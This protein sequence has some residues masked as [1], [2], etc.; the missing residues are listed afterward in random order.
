MSVN[1]EHQRFVKQVMEAAD[2]VDVISEVV[3]LKARS[4]ARSNSYMG[5]C[6]FHADRSPSFS[7]SGEKQL[8]HCFGCDAGLNGKQGGDVITFVRRQYDMKFREAV[9][10]L[11]KRYGIQAPPT[12]L[13]DERGAQ[14]TGV[15]DVPAGTLGLKARPTAFQFETKEDDGL[16]PEQRKERLLEPMRKAHALYASLYDSSHEAKNYLENVR[17]ISAQTLARFAIGFAPNG[18]DA[19]KPIYP[20]YAAEPRLLEAGLVKRSEKTSRY[21]D[22]FRNRVLFGIR[23]GRGDVVAY[24]GRRL[25][26]SESTQSNDQGGEQEQSFQGP[27]YLNSPDSPLFNKRELLFGLY[28]AQPRIS[29]TAQAI[30]V[31]GYMDVIGLANHGIDNAVASMG[32]AITGEQIQLL[33]RVGAKHIYFVMDGD[34]AG[35]KAMHRALEPLLQNYHPDV[36]IGFVELPDSLDPDEYIRAHSV[37]A[38]DQALSDSLD[39]QQFF[40][41]YL[42]HWAQTGLDSAYSQTRSLEHEINRLLGLIPPHFQH[43]PGVLALHQLANTQL[44]AL[45]E[46]IAQG[47]MQRSEDQQLIVQLPRYIKQLLIAANRLPILAL[48]QSVALDTLLD[49]TIP[50]HNV[51]YKQFHLAI[52]MG[53][54][55]SKSDESA[56][57]LD[58]VAKQVLTST[59]R[60][61]HE[62]AIQSAT[63]Y[64]KVQYAAGE[65]STQ[66]HLERLDKHARMREN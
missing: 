65:I 10:Y 28:E 31:E 6:P 44:Q 47:Q 62:F 25:Q 59:D 56:S 39:L 5:K 66:E 41:L 35:Q 29:T 27:K 51:L 54:N 8:Y 61:V 2:I 53:M 24:G 55:R 36:R 38:F 33:I 26:D 46:R 60:L 49:R 43:D 1:Y 42:E 15:K 7:V 40:A 19:L 14:S 9:D 17:G 18:F 52:G 64:A 63:D 58:E 12:W 30:V 11:G 4:G 16:S 22:F 20:N 45:T 34:M 13:A 21:Y 48:N 3:A 23:D 57:H 37:P 50:A 32:T